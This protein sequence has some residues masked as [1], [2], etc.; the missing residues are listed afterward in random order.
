MKAILMSADG[1]AYTD[2]VPSSKRQV[3]LRDGYHIITPVA[4]YRDIE[5]RRPSIAVYWQGRVTP[6]GGPGEEAPTHESA[7]T[8]FHEQAILKD[9]KAKAGVSKAWVRQVILA[10]V[11]FAKTFGMAF[12][13]AMMVMVL[14][15]FL[16]VLR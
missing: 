10:L 1:V 6:E 11:F 4:I 12:G 7:R 2:T 13:A 15:I 16:V 3:Q 5:H 8:F 14:Y 9:N